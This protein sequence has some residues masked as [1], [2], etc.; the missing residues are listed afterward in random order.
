MT[1]F[2]SIFDLWGVEF[3]LIHFFAMVL[4]SL[5]APSSPLFLFLFSFFCRVFV[6]FVS[7]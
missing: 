2:F 5:I 4:S 7:A 1:T 6:F 3:A